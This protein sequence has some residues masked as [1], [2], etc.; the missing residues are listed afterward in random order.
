MSSRAII[1]TY[2][3]HVIVWGGG[4]ELAEVEREREEEKRKDLIIIKMDR[5]NRI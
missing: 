1:T 5:E 4:E 2:I 3:A